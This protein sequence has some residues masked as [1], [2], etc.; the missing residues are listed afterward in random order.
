MDMTTLVG[1]LCSS[2]VGVRILIGGPSPM[3]L[4]SLNVLEA[5]GGHVLDLI[6]IFVFPGIALRTLLTNVP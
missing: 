3:F 2:T 4:I 1:A 6:C 5:S